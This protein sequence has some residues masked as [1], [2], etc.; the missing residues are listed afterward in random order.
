MQ[1]DGQYF[2]RGDEV[3]KAPMRDEASGTL[4]MGF[5]IATVSRDL[6]V[7]NAVAQ[8]IADALNAWNEKDKG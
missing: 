8:L 2:A 5:K 3:R 7:P 1:F 4:T 6:A